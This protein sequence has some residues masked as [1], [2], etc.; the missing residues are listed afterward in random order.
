MAEKY[1]PIDISNVPEL[2][3]I[4]EDVRLS[5]Q[6]CVL[7]RDSEDVAV[8]VPVP[9]K[10][11]RARRKAVDYEAVLG[12]AGSWRDLVDAEELKEQLTRARSSKPF[13]LD[14][15]EGPVLRQHN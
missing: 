5:R 9:T 6:P 3:R 11:R 10:G 4:V 12:T 8:V 7:R 14:C 15:I 13:D 1:E 2:V